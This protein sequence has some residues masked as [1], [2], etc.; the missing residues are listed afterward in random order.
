[1]IHVIGA[2]G[3]IGRAIWRAATGREDIIFYTS[4]KELAASSS[5]RYMTLEDSSSWSNLDIA[6]RDKIVFLP[7]RNLPNYN[8]AFHIS[9]NA[10]D[11]L[12]FFEY[13]LVKKI[14]KLVVSGTCYEY[15]LQNGMLS[16]HDPANPVNCY[17]VAKDCLRRM[18]QSIYEA[19]NVDLAWLR[20]FF[21]YGAGQSPRSLLPSLDLAI[22]NNME[23]FD[24]SQGDQIRDFIPVEEVASA[25]LKIADSDLAKGIINVGSGNPVSIRDFLERHIQRRDSCI[26]LRLGVYPRRFDEPLAFWAD[27]HKL[28]S[29]V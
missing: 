12:R 3:F 21:P 16:E 8:S 10:I 22:D 29:I 6:Q 5:A 27:I 28:R 1:M 24:T 23:F 20:L 4:K 9:T 11:S 13:L 17:A 18:T 15:G 26:R 19:N 25:F 14:S 7:W 2:S